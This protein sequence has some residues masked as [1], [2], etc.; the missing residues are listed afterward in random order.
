MVA[1]SL[2]T[3]NVKRPHQKL[4]GGQNN[5]IPG[6]IADADRRFNRIRQVVP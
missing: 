5:L 6:R 4:T 1:R 3:M 2:G